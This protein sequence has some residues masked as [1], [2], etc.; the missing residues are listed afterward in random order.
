MHDYGSWN[1][2]TSMIS[3]PHV[4]NYAVFHRQHSALTNI[5]VTTRLWLHLD[6]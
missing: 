1:H 4:Q 2:S 3:Y 6:I 5:G